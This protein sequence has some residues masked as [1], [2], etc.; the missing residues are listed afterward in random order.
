MSEAKR[1]IPPGLQHA[2]EPVEIDRADEA[3]LPVLLLRPR[4]GIEKIDAGQRR[5]RQPVEQLRRVV[6]VDAQIGRGGLPPAQPS[7]SPCQLTKGSTP[8]KPASGLAR[9]LV[10]QMLAAA[11]ADLQPDV[12]TPAR[13]TALRGRQ[14]AGA[15]RSSR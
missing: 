10:Q 4:V 3:P 9:G 7:A 2:R 1:N 6:V 15:A 8:M 13:E 5:V 14:G 11:E 12:A